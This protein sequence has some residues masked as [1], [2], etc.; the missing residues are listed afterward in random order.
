VTTDIEKLIQDARAEIEKELVQAIED[1]DAAN[2]RV[3][4]LRA[5]L[6]AAPR[7]HVRRTRKARVD[8]LVEDSGYTRAEAKVLVDEGMDVP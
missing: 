3:K 7:L 4:T 2:E 6:D 1:R 5:K 8:S